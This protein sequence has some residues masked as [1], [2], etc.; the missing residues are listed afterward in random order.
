[1]SVR[2]WVGIAFLALGVLFAICAG[3]CAAVETCCKR[4]ARV[5]PQENSG[6][7]RFFLSFQ[8]CFHHTVIEIARY[9]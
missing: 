6:N 2:A 3:I 1:M 5:N 4:F 7:T 9:T 8:I